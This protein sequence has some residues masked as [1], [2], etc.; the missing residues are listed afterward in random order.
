MAAKLT[1]QEASAQLAKL[2][3]WTLD[4]EKLRKNYEFSDFAH[5]FGFMTTA[6]IEIEKLGH[7]PDWTNVYNRVSVVLSTHDAGGLTAK[8]FQLAAL[9]DSLA[10]K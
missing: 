9:L 10:S 1:A 4:N 7:H 5:A 2:D 8:D 3:G 6:A